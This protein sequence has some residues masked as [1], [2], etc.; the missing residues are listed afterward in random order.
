MYKCKACGMQF[1]TQKKYIKHLE[2][3]KKTLYRH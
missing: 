1:S 2:I 3:F